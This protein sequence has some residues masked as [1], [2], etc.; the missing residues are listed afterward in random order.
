MLSLLL[1]LQRPDFF[2][3]N[4][5]EDLCGELSNTDGLCDDASVSMLQLH[6]VFRHRASPSPYLA[7]AEERRHL[8]PAKGRDVS[9]SEAPLLFL[10]IYTGPQHGSRRADIRASWLNHPLLAPGGPIAFRFVVGAAE[11]GSTASVALEAEVSQF[12]S[13]FLQLPIEDRYEKLT[14]KTFALLSWFAEHRPARFLMKTDDDTFPHLT[15]VVKV[16]EGQKQRYVYLGLFIDCAEVQHEGKNA[17]TAVGYNSS[18]YPLYA[19]GSGYLLSAELAVET[20]RAAASDGRRLFNEDTSV[21]AWVQIVNAS[22]ATPV[23]VVPLPSSMGMCS[24][25]DVLSLSMN[26]SALPC[27]WE[28]WRR[29]LGVCCGDHESQERAFPNLGVWKKHYPRGVELNSDAC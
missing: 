13:Q 4:S 10:A 28:R 9:A 3:A 14:N 17:E 7:L 20:A 11:P 22:E 8:L 5:S 15:E 24:P 26:S 27:M 23:H 1:L 12:R 29:G 16:L 21:G 19:H 2:A 6:T 18:V 25:G